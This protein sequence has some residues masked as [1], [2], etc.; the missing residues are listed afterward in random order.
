[1]AVLVHVAVLNPETTSASTKMYLFSMRC[2]QRTNIINLPGTLESLTL[3]EMLGW[4]LV[5]MSGLQPY[6][7]LWTSCDNGF[8]CYHGN[9]IGK[10]N[11]HNSDLSFLSGLI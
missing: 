6:P 8:I 10:T 9:T 1:M 11:Y 4:G 7:T 3:S 2:L 5:W